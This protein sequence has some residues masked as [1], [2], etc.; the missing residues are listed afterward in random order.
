MAAHIANQ[1]RALEASIFQGNRRANQK[2][3]ARQRLL[4]LLVV[5]VAV[6]VVV[7]CFQSDADH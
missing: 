5:A 7:G 4:L 3:E 6:M 1:S 2:G